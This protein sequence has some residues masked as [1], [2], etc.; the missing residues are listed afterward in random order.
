MPKEITS[1]QI[2]NKTTRQQHTDKGPHKTHAK[3]DS[4]Q[5]HKDH[6]THSSQTSVIIDK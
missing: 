2:D 6:T 5:I 1:Q 3:P 4:Q